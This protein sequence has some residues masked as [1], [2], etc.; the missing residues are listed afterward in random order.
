MTEEIWR[1]IEGWEGRYQVSNLTRVRSLL[2]SNLQPREEP[3]IKAQVNDSSGYK[4]CAFYYDGRMKMVK[5]HRLVAQAFIPNPENK[6]QVNHIDGDKHNNLPSN[7][8]WCTGQ[9]NM[10][11]AHETGLMHPPKGE[12]SGMA[13]WTEQEV[14]DIKTDINNGLSC[15]ELFE[16]YPKLDSKHLYLFRKNKTWTHLDIR[17]RE[18]IKIERK[19]RKSG[20]Y[21]EEQINAMAEYARNNPEQS[22]QKIANHFGVY[23]TLISKILRGVCVP[24]KELPKAERPLNKI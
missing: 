3:L 16:K 23:Q 14:I 11:H 15:V 22:Q 19:T 12:D 24:K 18:G 13:I 7:L 17:V 2:N 9:E 1:D 10:D 21:T 5:V 6:P 8:E 4:M 20:K